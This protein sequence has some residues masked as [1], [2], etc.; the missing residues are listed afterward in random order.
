MKD[1]IRHIFPE[2]LNSILNSYSQIFF[3][4]Y[5]VFAL[6]L[7]L[8]SFFDLSA[9]ISGLLA[10]IISNTTAYLVGFNRFNIK[11]GYYGFNALLVGLG[12]GI[13]YTVTPEYLLVLLFASIFTLFVTILLEGVVGKY[14]LP[15]LSIPFLI[16]LWV[17]ILASRLFTELTISDR[18][19]FMSNELYEIG[20]PVF[21]SVYEWLVN[22]NLH[23]SI[24]VY[25]RSLGAIFFQ[26]HLFAGI[27]IAIGLL[28]YSRI[29][30]VLSLVGYFSAYLFYTLVG[31]NIS[32]LSYSYIGFNFILSAIA[33]GG[34]YIIPSRHSFLWVIILTPLLS[35]TITASMAVFNIL[36]LSIYSLPFN[37]IVLMFL[38]ILKFRER[39][40]NKPE[41]VYYQQFSPEK[42]L[43]SQLN[44]KDRFE[45][46]RYFNLLL[47][48]WGEWSVT[49]AHDGEHTHKES[50]AHAWDFEIMD[51]EGSPFKNTGTLCEDFLCFNKPVIA[52]A[53]GSI[54]EVISTI[55]DNEIGD[56]NLEHNWGNTIIIKHAEGL[57]T[58]LCH[59]KK[60]SIQVKKGDLVNQGDIL[61]HVGNSGRSPQP[62]LHFQVQETPF[63]G[64]KTLDYP[65]GHYIRNVDSGFQFC[66]FSKP[67]YG[68]KV[69][70][71]EKNLNLDKAFHF[72]PGQQ[73]KFEVIAENNLTEDI[74]WEVRADIYNNTFLHYNKI[75]CLV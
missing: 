37:L 74:S 11:S 35:I 60:D 57:Y 54:E 73:L 13:Y 26:Y 70:N 3:S 75:N 21:V 2:F 59:L 31:G 62:H 56:M 47:P 40:F 8:V 39:Y 29:A 65:L 9:G 45:G 6:I 42:N 14:G 69:S 44:S 28:I 52:P 33:I 10:V 67:D 61:A 18:G 66:S 23:E 55:E 15:Y 72:I 20:G 64:S 27:I 48:F 17:I 24:I 34:F 7:L 50:W 19:I 41:V 68:D 30:F 58:K 25:Y 12:M 51:D 49:Q 1:K 16:G 46:H 22:L 32:E 53:D 63:I 43:Y 4:N 5:K 36:Q 71:I 38:Y